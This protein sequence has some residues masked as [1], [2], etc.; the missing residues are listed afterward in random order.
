MRNFFTEV[1]SKESPE[2]AAANKQYGI[3]KAGERF[4]SFFPRNLDNTPAY[5]RSSLLPTALTSAGVA[6]DE[7][8]EGALQG[9]LAAAI[10]SPAS[11]GSIIAAAGVGAKATPQIKHAVKS[12]ISNIISEKLKSK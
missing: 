7:P 1:I 4:K 2:L 5:F 6:R 12:V 9:G 8:I 3:A 10:L 11:I